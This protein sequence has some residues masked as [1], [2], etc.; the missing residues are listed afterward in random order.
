[1]QNLD[2]LKVNPAWVANLLNGFKQAVP[3]LLHLPS[4]LFTLR[5]GGPAAAPDKPPGEVPWPFRNFFL[6][7][8]PERYAVEYDESRMRR[9]FWCC[10]LGGNS[11]LLQS[12]GTSEKTPI[13][14]EIG[15][16]E[17]RPEGGLV[18]KTEP[19]LM[20]TYVTGPL[21]L[22]QMTVDGLLRLDPAAAGQSYHA[23]TAT[24]KFWPAR[25]EWT[26]LL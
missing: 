14:S 8:A 16:Y 1:M 10:W 3:V 22:I 13:G 15:V 23:L 21:N 6:E 2:R 20:G 18:C 25:A 9:G 12:F 5:R 4:I 17:W 24:E 11:F 26:D 19:Q 7:W